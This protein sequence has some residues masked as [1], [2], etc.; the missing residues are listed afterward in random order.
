[1]VLEFDKGSV[2]TNSNRVLSLKESMFGILQDFIIRGSVPAFLES[3]DLADI[4]NNGAKYVDK[5]FGG[6]RKT[7]EVILS[8]ITKNADNPDL[9]ARAY[10]KGEPTVFRG[11]SDMRFGYNNASS[12]IVH[13]YFK[14]GLTSLIVTDDLQPTRQDNILG[15]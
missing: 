5:K 15:K 11:L 7:I 10:K 8:V 13:N 2:M 1:M 3:D 6:T 4:M 9:Y 14:G 12:K